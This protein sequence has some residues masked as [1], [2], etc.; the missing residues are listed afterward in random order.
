MANR[1]NR[2]KDPNGV[3]IARWIIRLFFIFWAVVVAFPVIWTLYTSLKSNQEFF[4]NPLALPEQLQWENFLDA[5]N[6]ANFGDYFFNSLL[7][8]L[9]TLA[10]SLL[11][12]STSAYVIAKYKSRWVG[13]LEKF[14]MVAMMIPSVLTL[15]PLYY[16][17]ESITESAGLPLTDNLIS[18][19]IMYAITGMPFYIFMLTGFMRGI[20]N[21]LIEAAELDGASQFSIFFKII[22][23][24]I[25]PS[26]FVV[27]LLN[28]MGTWNEYMT[29]LTFLHDESNYTIAIG[30]SYLTNASTYDVNY[31]RLFAGLAIALVPILIMYA[32]FQKQLQNGIASNEGVKG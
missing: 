20:N 27:G 26:L 9:V 21:S 12:V 15:V 10:I 17:S 2:I 19:S 11:V 28:V 8:V 24:L 7:T 1:K 6:E 4:S 16:M 5:W 13:V 22:L 32:C 25:K 3:L 31:G 14:Y 18:L 29:A 30:L 23:P